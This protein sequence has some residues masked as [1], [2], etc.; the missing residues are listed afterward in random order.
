LYELLVDNDV[1]P[2]SDMTFWS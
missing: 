2:F 1:L